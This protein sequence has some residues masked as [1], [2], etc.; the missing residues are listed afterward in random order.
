MATRLAISLT[1]RRIRSR[2]KPMIL[3][4]EFLFLINHSNI[5]NRY[6]WIADSQETCSSETENIKSDLPSKEKEERKE[7]TGLSGS[8]AFQQ[9]LRP[10]RQLLCRY[11]L[12]SYTGYKTPTCIQTF[13]LTINGVSIYLIRYEVSFFKSKS[14]SATGRHKVKWC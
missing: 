9:W 2:K 14:E 3:N 10:L 7:G 11:L 6:F 13:P 4:D 8:T 12:T 1:S 5:M